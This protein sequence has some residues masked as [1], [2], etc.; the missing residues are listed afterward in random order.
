MTSAETI[1]DIV[2]EIRACKT[3]G[4]R[5]GKDAFWELA[6][7]IDAAVRVDDALRSDAVT[8]IE[9]ALCDVE[10]DTPNPK[11]IRWLLSEVALVL[12]GNIAPV[13]GMVRAPDG[14]GWIDPPK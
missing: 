9:A 12:G 10:S 2:A 8:K 6:D 7:R 5:F 13:R 11:T 14:N 1:A 4:E 3:S